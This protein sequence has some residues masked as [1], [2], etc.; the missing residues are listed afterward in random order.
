MLKHMSDDQTAFCP[1]VC[2]K[3]KTPWESSK[4]GTIFKDLGNQTLHLSLV[5]GPAGRGVPASPGPHPLQEHGAY[6]VS[7]GDMKGGE[8]APPGCAEFL[9]GLPDMMVPFAPRKGTYHVSAASS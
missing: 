4:Q 2:F 3:K 6:T 5:D 8:L 9:L 7:H 1:K